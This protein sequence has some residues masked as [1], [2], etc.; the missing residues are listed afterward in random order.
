MKDFTILVGGQAGQ[1]SR[2]AGLVVA[3]ILN[4]LGY[5]IFIY[6]DYESLIKG[7]HSFSKIRASQEKVL[8][9]EDKVDFILALNE[10]TLNKHRS[11]LK[12]NG[13][14]IFN[15]DKIK[16]QD[17]I[18]INIETITKEEGGSPIMANTAM[19]AAFAKT[20]GIEF[21][22]FKAILEKEIKKYLDLNF[23]I[24][25]RIY[26]DVEQK[27]KLEKLDN[28]PL[29]LITGNEALALGATKA[30]LD[31]Y[32]AYPMTPATSI[33]HFLAE[34]KLGVNTIQLENEIS[35]IISA[36]GSAYAGKRTMI[37]TSGGGFALMTEGISLAAIAE[38]PLVIVN[39]QRTGPA[40]GVPTYTG[41]SDLNFV[42]NAGHGDIVKFTVAPS[43][44]E[45]CY[46]WGGRLLNLAWKY[47]TPAVLLIDKEISESTFNL[48]V[49]KEIKKEEAFLWNRQGDYKRY[50][51]TEN[52]ISALAFP[53]DEAVVKVTSYEHDEFGFTAE[54]K[55]GDIVAMQEKRLRK[56]ESMQEEVD[57][58]EDAI[59][60]Y[61]KKDS[62]N[63]LITWGS[64]TAPSIE[65]A[66]NFDL[67]VIQVIV[68]EPFPIV[69]I[70]KELEDT[71]L[72]ICVEQNALGQLASLLS[73]N[74]ID[75]SELI[76]KYSSRVLQKE[77][78]ED[79]L[80]EII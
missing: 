11:K 42:L 16:S 73:K 6:D 75:A 44:A 29:P 43:N 4:N 65:A 31:I 17:G 15:A 51:I 68:L 14:I 8:T 56:Y 52:G 9:Q 59:K 70:L 55:E 26:N 62:K 20:V 30:G 13:I 32:Y 50:E 45:E 67:K 76:L 2:K 19:I 25:E 21:N 64:S 40:T 24:A 47:Q 28:K 22:L 69:Q 78:V 63:V 35:V 3:K 58:M 46:E 18:G 7:G 48:E 49:K 74:G 77:E 60:I 66:M 1:G 27:L 54:D 10:E 79:L 71:E 39:S 61:G 38:L 5:R 72:I 80:K 37:G 12:D 36:L 33:L 57:Q 53:G 34:H 23:K 41:Q